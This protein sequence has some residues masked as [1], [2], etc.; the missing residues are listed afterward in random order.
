M[1][2]QQLHRGFFLEF[3][4][5]LSEGTMHNTNDIIDL[6]YVRELNLEGGAYGF[7]V[8]IRKAL[9]KLKTHSDRL[10]FVGD[11]ITRV[12]TAIHRRRPTGREFSYTID[13]LLSERLDEL[14]EIYDKI[15][16]EEHQ[17]ESLF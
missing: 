10:N 12:K 1:S 3:Y 16:N 17:Q 7:Y 13:L 9:E 15:L 5:E 11:Q 8:N 14:Y 6:R 2:R 4:V